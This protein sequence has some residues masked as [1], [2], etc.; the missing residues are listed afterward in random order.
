[1]SA[2]RSRER[3]Q[4]VKRWQS[5]TGKKE[6]SFSKCNRFDG[7]GFELIRPAWR[8]LT[9]VLL[10]FWPESTNRRPGDPELGKASCRS[11]NA[12]AAT[13]AS[14]ETILRSNCSWRLAELQKLSSPPEVDASRR[15]RCR[16]CGWPLFPAFH[17]ER[18]YA[19]EIV[20]QDRIHRW[21]FMESNSDRKHRL[22]NVTFS[23][24]FPFSPSLVSFIVRWETFQSSH[25][26]KYYDL[27]VG[28]YG[29]ESK[30]DRTMRDPF[31]SYFYYQTS[32]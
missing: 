13:S 8:P 1:M 26:M 6:A 22:V 2:K 32:A 11:R 5:R 27:P 3:C 19:R 31:A 17:P 23:L 29:W 4:S 25:A 21:R 18:S 16:L 10:L 7:H 30:E 14:L 12:V 9:W 28:M 15:S 20:H 24:V